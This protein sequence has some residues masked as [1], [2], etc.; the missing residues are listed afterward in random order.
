[1]NVSLPTI[2]GTP[3]VGQ[4][5][6]AHPGA[7]ADSNVPLVFSF[8]WQR[9]DAQGQGCTDI[10]GATGQMYLLTAADAGNRL[11]VVVTATDQAQKSSAAAS[12]LTA[13]VDTGPVN[14]AKPAITG[15]PSIGQTLTTT[16]GTW[17]GRTR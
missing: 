6:N 3:R 15:T 7:W 1:V 8:R 2:S 13:L 17:V 12:G 14:T 9:C 11:I 10:P 4:T 5:L 16:D